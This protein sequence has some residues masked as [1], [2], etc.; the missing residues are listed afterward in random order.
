MKWMYVGTKYLFDMTPKGVNSSHREGYT[1]AIDRKAFNTEPYSNW[2]A[3]N[4]VLQRST[5]E[6]VTGGEASWALLG[7]EIYAPFPS[8][9]HY[10]EF[11]IA[12]EV[13]GGYEMIGTATLYYDLDVPGDGAKIQGKDGNQWDGQG[14]GAFHFRYVKQGD[15]D[16]RLAASTI[17]ADPTPAMM[18][19]VHRGM[20]KP[21][22]FV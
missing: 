8:H 4:H 11:A 10:P 13:E 3:P 5:G 17:Y 22:N 21:E 19:M 1:A 9:V 12:W 14:P 7:K 15:G 16:L 6:V 2:M 20:L 18:L